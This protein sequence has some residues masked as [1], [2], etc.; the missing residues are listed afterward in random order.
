MTQVITLKNPFYNGFEDANDPVALEYLAKLKT[1][2]NA[3]KSGTLYVRFIDG[4]RK[5]S[6]AH[7]KVHPQL[8]YDEP[9]IGYHRSYYNN[10]HYRITNESRFGVLTWDKRKNKVRHYFPTPRDEVEYLIGY[11]GPTIWEKFDAKAAKEEILQ[12][13]TEHDING[14]YLSVGD[15]VLYVNIRYGSGTTLEIGTIKEFKVSVDSKR[16][17]VSTVIESDAGV[18][19]TLKY[20][21]SMVCKIKDD[22]VS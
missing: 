8:T 16:A 18:L 10:S 11:D 13:Q 9:C 2:F 4:D 14:N 21:S 19:S 17:E 22:N 1:V 15:R 12:L 3:F 7:L 6:I 5:G 20:P